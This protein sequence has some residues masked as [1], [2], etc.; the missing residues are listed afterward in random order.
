MVRSP[1]LTLESL[2]IDLQVGNKPVRYPWQPLSHHRSTSLKS[3]SIKGFELPEDSFFQKLP[4]SLI[5][6]KI[7]LVMDANAIEAFKANGIVG[8]Y[9][10]MH[11]RANI[12]FNR[13]FTNQF[14]F[15]FLT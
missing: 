3:L 5:S 2:K 7:E 9:Q 11:P 10:E 8:K 15:H 4:D 12:Q 1:L 13:K 6:L 14:V